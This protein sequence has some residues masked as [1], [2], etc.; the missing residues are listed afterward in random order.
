MR[1]EG[2]ELS[3]IKCNI[4]INGMIFEFETSGN[5][6]KLEFKFCAKVDK[7]ATGM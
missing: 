2:I 3:I 5:H 1:W 4:K 7:L 6:L